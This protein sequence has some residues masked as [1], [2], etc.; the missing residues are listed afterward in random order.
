LA[1][2]IGKG[3]NIK[4]AF[5]LANEY[6]KEGLTNSIELGQGIKVTNPLSKIYEYS[7]R[8][9]VILSLN[10]SISKL[11][12]LKGFY[13]LIPETKTNFVYSLESPQSFNDVA[14]IK[15]RI[16]N[17]D[18]KIRIPNIVEF[19]ASKHVA[20]AV[21]SANKINNSIRSA[22]NIK[23]DDTILSVCKENFK[24][25]FYSRQEEKVEN[26]V[27]EGMSISWGIK[28]ALDKDPDA[29]I[30]YH[31][32]DYGKEPMIII[33]GNSPEEILDKIKIIMVN[34]ST[35]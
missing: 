13:M 34:T 1:S 30:V 23:K 2:F 19:G 16:T 3:H 9:K 24:C 22:I 17:I 6:V 14:G 11:E 8:F 10:N 33:F 31:D 35:F 21:I 25:S 7:S 5:F 32:G 20:N 4:D 18:S 12:D 27:I 26:K 29:K 15:G 28:K